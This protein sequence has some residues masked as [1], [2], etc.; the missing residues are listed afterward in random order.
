MLNTDRGPRHRNSVTLTIKVNK[1]R[2]T[3]VIFPTQHKRYPA[4]LGSHRAASEA[5]V[6]MVGMKGSWWYPAIALHN[7][8]GVLCDLPL[9]VSSYVHC[10]LSLS[11]PH[12]ACPTHLT[13]TLVFPLAPLCPEADPRTRAGPDIHCSHVAPSRDLV[14][15]SSSMDEG[16]DQIHFAPDRDRKMEKGTYSWSPRDC[17]RL[18][19]PF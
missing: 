9:S 13:T 19:C 7:P 14:P 8:Q 4:I 3:Q 15:S 17:L 5:L 11:S 16:K 6:T 18:A 1:L 12:C 2:V 10:P